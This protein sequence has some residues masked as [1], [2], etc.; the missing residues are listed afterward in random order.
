MSKFTQV[1]MC[2]CLMFSASSLMIVSTIIK[3]RWG[4]W[5][6]LIAWMIAAGAW[7]FSFYNLV[8]S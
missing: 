3:S 7:G 5:A 8:K 1:W 4:W 2:N 6:A